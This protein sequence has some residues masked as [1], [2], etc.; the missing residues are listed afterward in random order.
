MHFAR[1]FG[2]V[3]A[4]IIRVGDNL[5]M[6]LAD[7]AAQ[8]LLL[9]IKQCNILYLWRRS[10]SRSPEKAAPVKAA[11]APAAEAGAELAAEPAAP[12]PQPAK[13]GNPAAS[14]SDSEP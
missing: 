10:R 12:L 4:D 3:F 6:Q 2:K 13:S 7:H 1:F 14:G 11:V 8:L 5:F 9:L